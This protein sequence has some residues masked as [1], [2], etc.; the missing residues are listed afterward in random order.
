MSLTFSA[1]GQ[2]KM[3]PPIP[4]EI[5]FGHNKY[6]AQLILNRQLP[7]T[8]KFYF[9]SVNYVEIDY[10][11]NS[12]SLEFVSASQIAFDLHKGFGVTTGLSANRGG[13]AP[14]LGLRYI[15][16]HP[17]FVVGLFP[18]F[19]FTKDK[20][21]SLFG[22]VE[23]RPKL[24]EKLSLYSRVQGL[25]SHNLSLQDHERSYMQFRLGIGIKRY[26]FGLSANLDYY[27]PMKA[28]ADNY[29][30]FLKVNL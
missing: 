20:N 5:N 14:S 6:A 12:N 7:G 17:E 30:V 1:I 22:L 10:E 27:N 16:A 8:K 23:Y 24:T 9:F 4:F 25:Y 11:N 2:E 3:S 26:D 15:Y 18:A 21:I 29:G 28:F 13:M 19:V